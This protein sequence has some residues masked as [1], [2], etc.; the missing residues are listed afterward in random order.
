MENMRADGRGRG[1]GD[2]RYA[3]GM[4]ADTVVWMRGRTVVPKRGRIVVVI[5]ATFVVVVVIVRSMVS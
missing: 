4:R 1:L 5:R 3:V 2:R